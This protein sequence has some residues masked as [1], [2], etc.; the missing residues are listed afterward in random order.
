MLDAYVE[1]QIEGGQLDNAVKI[2]RSALRDGENVWIKREDSTLEIRPVTITARDPGHVYV[3]E[4][5]RAGEHLITSDIPVATPG[6]D[7]REEGL[8]SASMPQRPESGSR[9]TKPKQ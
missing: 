3:T 4:G 6:M 8:G 9:T 5:L 7:L 1:A 2:P